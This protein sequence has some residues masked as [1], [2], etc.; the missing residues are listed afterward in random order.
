MG[1]IERIIYFFSERVLFCTIGAVTRICS[2]EKH[3]QHPYDWIF[4]HG[5]IEAITAYKPKRIYIIANEDDIPMRYVYEEDVER[6]Y[7]AVKSVL[8]ACTHAYVDY[9][10]CKSKDPSSPL[11]MPNTGIIEFFSREHVGEEF[12]P[13][14]ILLVGDCKEARQCAERVGC[15]YMSVL[16]FIETY[17]DK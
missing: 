17:R 6:K 15:G 11:R 9:M 1:I 7:N 12:N 13:S 4:R 5:V 10:Y 8:H 3:P 16:D 14:K 2:G